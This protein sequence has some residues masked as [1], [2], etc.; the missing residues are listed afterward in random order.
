MTPRLQDSN[1]TLLVHWILPQLPQPTIT[2][3]CPVIDALTTFELADRVAE[4]DM[5]RHSDNKNIRIS[6]NVILQV[7]TPR[8]QPRDRP[9]DA[10]RAFQ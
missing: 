5:E 10:L 6:S 9:R 4:N 7:I 3:S 2:P 1:V 8:D